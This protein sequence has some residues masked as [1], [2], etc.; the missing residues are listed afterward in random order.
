[1]ALL[2]TITLVLAAWAQTTGLLVSPGGLVSAGGSMSGTDIEI[3]GSLGSPF[4]TVPVANASGVRVASGLLAGSPSTTAGGDIDGDSDVDFTDFLLFAGAFGK[5]VGEPLFVGA[6]D[7]DSNGTVD[8]GDFLI[9]A[10]A[11]GS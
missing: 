3:T 10:S 4:S 9:L 1:M 5:S 2:V 8:F 7:I 11:F 6:A